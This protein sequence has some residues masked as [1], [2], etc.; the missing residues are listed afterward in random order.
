VAESQNM[1]AKERRQQQ[2]AR[3]IE[4]NANNIR[5]AAEVAIATKNPYAM[6]AGAAVKGLDKITGGK[7][8]QALAKATNEAN[9]MTPGGD[10]I[11]KNLNKMS[12]SGASDA[13]GKVAAMKNK[14]SGSNASK[15][16]T[17][18]SNASKASEGAKGSKLSNS[19]KGLNNSGFG[20]SKSGLFSPKSG[21]SERQSDS[22]SGDVSAS[23][24]KASNAIKIFA[25]IAPVLF[26]MILCAVIAFVVIGQ[27]MM[28]WENIEALAAQFDTGIEKFGNLL[29]GNGYATNE[30][31]FFNKLEEEYKNFPYVGGDRLDVALIAATIHYSTTVDLNQ[32]ENPSSEET[33][34]GETIENPEDVPI[35][36]TLNAKNTSAFYRRA[37]DMLGSPYSKA[38]GG[39]R[40]LGYAVTKDVSLKLYTWGELSVA[41]SEWSQLFNLMHET[42]GDTF[43]DVY[44]D[45]IIAYTNPLTSAV[46]F[47]NLY[48][49][50]TSYLNENRSILDAWEYD[51]RNQYYE[52]QELWYRLTH[53]F[54]NTKNI[55][56]TDTEPEDKKG[57]AW[58]PAPDVSITMNYGYDE[59]KQ[60][61][62]DINEMKAILTMNGVSFDS[63]TAVLDNAKNSSNT[64][65][66]N[67]YEDYKKNQ[68]RYMYSYTHYLQNVYVPFN[69]C[70]KRECGINEIDKMIDEIFDQRDFYYYLMGDE[71]ALTSV[72]GYSYSGEPV[73]VNIDTAMLNN[74]YVNV[75]HYSENDRN[76]TNIAET[77]S[78]RDYV[79][80]VLYREVGAT[81]SD[82]AEYLKANIVAI[83]SYT[84][85][86]PKVM[87]DSIT[88]DSGKYY[89]TM[90]NNTNDQV[91]CSLTKG[92]MDAPDNKKQAPSSELIDYLG[93]LYDEVANQFLYDSAT[94]NFTGSY[95]SK[96]SKCAAD[97]AT[98]YCMGQEES[99]QLGESGN[100]WE[101][102]LA[103]FYESSIGIVDIA[104]STLSTSVLSCITPG[105]QLGHSG[106]SVRTSAPTSGSKY[107]IPPWNQNTLAQCVWYA[108][109]RALEIVDTV[110]ASQEKKDKAI[111]TIKQINAN[112]NGWYHEKLLE[113]FAHS[114][115]YTLPI[116]GALVVYDWVNP[117]EKGNRYGHVAIVEKVEG[118]LVY[119]SDGWNSCGGAYG[120]ASW[121]CVGF[122]YK[123]FTIEQM[124]NLG[125][126]DYYKFVGYV[127]LLD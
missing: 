43:Q 45:S 37:I 109:G 110:N 9:K 21:S 74:L 63:D 17:G 86:R 54:E 79:I 99:K 3:N 56:E 12:E 33:E 61:Q 77:V 30:G 113:V 13:I 2:D 100:N 5:N 119:V 55:Q 25:M 39:K 106:Y 83:K 117:D 98:G 60:M 18:A 52:I 49:K 124:Q 87:G 115:D 41:A 27:V 120:Q 26:P 107:F 7:S 80:G 59:Y 15:A 116:E 66:K 105:L 14:A 70:Y 81:T 28:I 50:M 29:Q 48:D 44:W 73:Q 123:S 72:C 58:I 31:A 16:S 101:T 67:L 8:T 126:P 10:K 40:L 104:T 125:R 118:D 112:G 122:R 20:N 76:S 92:C 35:T 22:A 75:L 78:L 94:G 62:R 97:G 89:L 47:N 64:Q 42:V 103:T 85:G 111:E 93:R 127:Y 38:S 68:S 36:G 96:S 102:I 69:Y 91:Y 1:S 34:S 114:T 23:F 84:I 51:T 65:L 6:A 121:D 95:R 108:K 19:A 90:R 46:A 71:A 24:K 53:L 11:Q 4:N 82:N 88:S 57:I 32:F